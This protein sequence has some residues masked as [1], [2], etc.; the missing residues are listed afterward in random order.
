MI[1]ITAIVAG[2]LTVGLLVLMYAIVL[3][4]IRGPQ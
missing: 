1:D 4:E 3:T 2:A